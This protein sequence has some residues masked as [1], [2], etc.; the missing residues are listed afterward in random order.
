M[1]L[2]PLLVIA[3]CLFVLG[4]SV[5]KSLKEQDAKYYS[6][7]TKIGNELYPALTE[8]SPSIKKYIETKDESA[9][10]NLEVEAEK[11]RNKMIDLQKRMKEI[12]PTEGQES[13]HQYVIDR[14]KD[15]ENFANSVIRFS[16]GDDD[17]WIQAQMELKRGYTDSLNE[18]FVYAKNYKE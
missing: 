7:M 18:I 1:K 8:L 13:N 14:I 4:C 2:K 11:Y 5:Q 15:L 12:K 17:K 9:A 10:K 6:Q 16:G 3:L